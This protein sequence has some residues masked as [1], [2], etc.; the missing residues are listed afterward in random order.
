MAQLGMKSLEVREAEPRSKGLDPMRMRLNASGP[1]TDYSGAVPPATSN[2]GYALCDSQPLL[3]RPEIVPDMSLQSFRRQSMSYA[4]SL[5]PLGIVS[6]HFDV[7]VTVVNYTYIVLGG[8][9]GS[10][11]S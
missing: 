9:F 1:R 4:S 7:I 10:L 6:P 8:R 5:R 3:Y 11:V 2:H